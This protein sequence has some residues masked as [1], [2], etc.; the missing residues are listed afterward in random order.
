M[1]KYLLL[2]IFP[3]ILFSFISDNHKKP[4]VPIPY[5]TGEYISYRVHYGFINAGEALIQVDDKLYMINNKV[6]HKASVVGSTT[7]PFDMAMRIRDSWAT[8]LD[9]IN[10]IPLRAVRDI[11]ENKYRLREYTNYDYK[12]N[13][14]T[15]EREGSTTPAICYKVPTDVQDV[16]SGFFYLRNVD[17]SKKKFGD[18]I[19]I[20]AFLE[21]RV[22]LFKVKYSGKEKLDTKLGDINCLRLNPVMEKNGLFESG[23]S[24]RFWIS[25]DLNKIPIR[26]EADM[27]VGKV[28]MDIKKYKN[29]RNPI[30]FED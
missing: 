25:D 19:S 30:K 8:Y 6:C 4:Q 17:F 9:T 5:G 23:N 24:I 21:D 29:L 16:V 3:T 26:I 20:N 12:N 18:T 15:V 14:V 2:I 22:Y 10:R 11:A 27:W 28:A 13:Q 1:N 7:G